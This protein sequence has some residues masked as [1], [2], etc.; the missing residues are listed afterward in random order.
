MRV[1]EVVSAIGDQVIDLEKAALCPT[2]LMARRKAA[3][4]NL[5]A[6]EAE[7]ISEFRVS[8]VVRSASSSQSCLAPWVD[9]RGTGE[10]LYDRAAR[11]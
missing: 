1:L 9:N 11:C 8:C 3:L 6:A 2:S 7:H 10:R 4:Q 5:C